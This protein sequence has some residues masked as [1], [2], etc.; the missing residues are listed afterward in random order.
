VFRELGGQVLIFS[1]PGGASGGAGG[2]GLKRR[3]EKARPP[4][5]G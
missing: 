3:S 4:R 2:F 1:F 5:R